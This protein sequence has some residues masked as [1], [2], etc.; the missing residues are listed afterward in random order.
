MRGLVGCGEVELL[1][2][3]SSCNT[4]KAKSVVLIGFA[5]VVYVIWGVTLHIVCHLSNGSN[6]FNVISRIRYMNSLSRGMTFL[7]HMTLNILLCTCTLEQF[8]ECLP[9]VSNSV[10]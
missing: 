7:S 10:S 3:Y 2:R 1:V 8:M 4:W 6:L 5:C 9:K